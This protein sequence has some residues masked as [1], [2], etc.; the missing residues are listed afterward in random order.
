MEV[1]TTILQNTIV[2][3]YG[4]LTLVKG[5]LNYYGKLQQY[6]TAVFITLALDVSK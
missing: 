4:N 3:D 1:N 6:F 5:E 2:I